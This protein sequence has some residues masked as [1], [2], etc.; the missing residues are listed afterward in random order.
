MRILMLSCNT[1]EGHNSTGNAVREVLEAR[2]VECEM[3]VVLGTC[4][5]PMFSKLICSTH[6]RLYKY[7]P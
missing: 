3:I 5:S 7:A 6:A 1:G 4:I 2:G